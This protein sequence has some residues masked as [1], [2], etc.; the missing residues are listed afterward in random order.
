MVLMQVTVPDGLFPGDSMN[1][2]V[3][4]QEFTIT[5]PDGVLGGDAIDVD[6]P[7]AEEEPAEEQGAATTMVSI[8]V[9]DGCYEGTEFTVEFDGREFNIVVPDGVGP[10]ETIEVAAATRSQCI[11]RGIS[12]VS[13]CHP[14]GISYLRAVSVGVR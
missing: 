8:V 1:I 2:A 14:R 12:V 13:P 7:V 3:G 10:G 9:P 6:L 5:V 11:I 4:E